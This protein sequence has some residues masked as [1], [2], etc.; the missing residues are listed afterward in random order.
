[1]RDI[2]KRT[3]PA[4]LAA[5]RCAAHADYDNLSLPAKDELRAALV[6]EQRGLCCYCMS[7][8]TDDSGSAKIEH[9]RC[10]SRYP[11]EQLVYRNLLTAC[12]GGNGRPPRLQ[13]CD[14]RKGDDDLSRNPADPADR[15][16]HFIS[17][18]PDGS[19]YAS[20]TA[21]DNE[22]N[23]VLNLNVALLKNNRQAALDGFLDAR[24]RGGRW[25]DAEL[26]R[27]LDEWAGAAGGGALRPYCQIIVYWIRRRLGRSGA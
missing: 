24:P 16:E 2:A 4:S 12:P 11:A 26:Q 6:S 23:D 7:R 20:D 8:I 17:Y 15:V 10:Q 5:H 9:W 21:F 27:W 25:A 13:H 3:E 14:T 22:I 18:G 1:M 19:I